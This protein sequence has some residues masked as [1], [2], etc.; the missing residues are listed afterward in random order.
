MGQYNRPSKLVSEYGNVPMDAEVVAALAQG[1]P[2]PKWQRQNR[3]A[4]ARREKNQR[5]ADAIAQQ[6]L[7]AERGHNFQPT[8]QDKDKED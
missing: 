7:A 4:R 1:L 5:E 2:N 6:T 3:I 8:K